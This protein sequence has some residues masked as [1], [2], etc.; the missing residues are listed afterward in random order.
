[1]AK[2]IVVLLVGVVISGLG[3]VLLSKGM[4]SVGE[5]VQPA[6]PLGPRLI[7]AV[8]NPW[9]LSGVAL[10]ALFFA[11]YLVLLSRTDVSQLLPMT[12]LDY[13]VIAVLAHLMLGEAV[14]GVRWAGIVLVVAGVVLVSRS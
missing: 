13:I 6:G 14:T 8:T 12:A 2:T 1:M 11:I 9:V 7:H 3:H 4:R 5:L 10:Q